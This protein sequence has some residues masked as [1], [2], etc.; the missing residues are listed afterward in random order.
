MHLYMGERCKV[1]K[2]DRPRHCACWTTVHFKDTQAH[3]IF[4]TQA[5]SHPP[6]PLN[7]PDSCPHVPRAGLERPLDCRECDQ[8]ERALTD[9]RLAL[10]QILRDLH[11]A[12]GQL[13]LLRACVCCFQIV[14]SDHWMDF[15]NSYEKC[16]KT[17][18]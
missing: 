14:T 9:K 10:V 13:R 5:A 15:I 4:F 18:V 16:L 8:T 17:I 1:E 11:I 2:R 3:H 12:L 7:T 6:S